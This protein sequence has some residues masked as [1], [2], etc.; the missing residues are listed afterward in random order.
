MRSLR[1]PHRPPDIVQIEMLK[2]CR[3]RLTGRY[4]RRAADP[5]GNALQDQ[6]ID[7][8]FMIQAEGTINLGP[9]YGSVRVAGLTLDEIS[10]PSGVSSTRCSIA[11]SL[12][13]W[14]GAQACNRSPGSTSSARTAPSTFASTAGRGHGQDDRRRQRAV[15]KQLS[16]YLSSPTLSVE[17]VAYNSKVYYV[18]TQGREWAIMS[19]APDHR[20][21]DGAGCPRQLNGLSQ[22]PARR[23]GFLGR[24]ERL[25]ERHE[26]AVDYDAITQRGATATNYQIMPG[27]RLFIAEDPAVA[28]TTIS[29][30]RPPPSSAC[31][32]DRLATN[33]L[34]NLLNLASPQAPQV[35]KSRAATLKWSTY[36]RNPY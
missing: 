29:P 21:R 19:E 14:H 4:F 24:P 15:E 34:Q 7:D 12:G 6:P 11:G 1:L 2:M 28:L 13:Q 3:F 18:V 32:P 16:R 10:R 35:M 33:D 27:D 25:R 9:T 17:V 23:S 31:W 22:F 26:L 8:N 5:R 30:K 20:Q 36:E